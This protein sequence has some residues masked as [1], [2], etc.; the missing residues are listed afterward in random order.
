M[1]SAL[2]DDLNAEYA[3]GRR[4]TQT[5]CAVTKTMYFLIYRRGGPRVGER[6]FKGS[7]RYVGLTKPARTAAAGWIM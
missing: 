2:K 7:E 3:K 4:E 5:V 6:S 1:I